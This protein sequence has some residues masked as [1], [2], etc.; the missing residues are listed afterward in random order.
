MISLANASIQKIIV[1]KVGNK[2][3]EENVYLSKKELELEEDM[4]EV[5]HD[6]FFS[7]FKSEE[8]FHLYDD[9][10]LNENKVFSSVSTIFS[11]PS[12][13]IEESVE[14]ANHLFEQS[15]HP[16]ILKGELY[17]AILNGCILDGE[18][19]NAIGIFKSELKEPFLKVFQTGESFAIHYDEGIN[20]KKLDK[21]CI[22]FNTEKED[23]Y[24][25]SA[26]DNTNKNADAQYWKDDFLKIKSR[27]DNYYHTQNVM[28]F[29]KSFVK[30]Q[31]PEE[32]EISKADQAFI[33]NKSAKFLKEKES[34]EFNEFAAEVFEVPEIV[35]SVKNYRQNYE[36]QTDMPLADEFDISTQA[37][38]KQ[39]RFM[40][41]V[42]K[43][44]KN[45]HIYV[46]GKRQYIQRGY[47]E[48]KGMHYY[49]IYFN[50]EK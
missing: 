12:L 13:F 5:L 11:D 14:I 22:V 34:F 27:V 3:L 37:Y 16:N 18:E 19:V 10:D 32:Y 44:D 20:I 1:H 50:E 31:L 35:E 36:Q 30:E 6:Y 26:I 39:A 46:H 24:I 15:N 40:K 4:K 21:G 45:F 23:G 8:Y 17:I 43:L 38:K 9:S 42:I 33:L 28:S 25:V 49:Q 47:D 2:Q 48:E 7:P 29:C 41:S